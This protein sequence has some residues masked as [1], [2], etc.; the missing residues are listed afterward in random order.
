[1]ESK[2]RLKNQMSVEN[3]IIRADYLIYNNG[4]LNDLYKEI[5]KWLK[6]YVRI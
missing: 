5:K 2:E 6:E 3:K 4:S 1:M